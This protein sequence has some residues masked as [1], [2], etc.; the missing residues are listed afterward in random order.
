MSVAFKND[1]PG[2]TISSCVGLSARPHIVGVGRL[3]GDVVCKQVRVRVQRQTAQNTPHD[4]SRVVVG[5]GMQ[6]A[7][8]SAPFLRPRSAPVTIRSSG[9]EPAR[10]ITARLPAGIGLAGMA[11]WTGV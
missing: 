10:P 4:H 8:S 2:C 3:P 7:S 5:P 1:P 6:G 9:V 11:R